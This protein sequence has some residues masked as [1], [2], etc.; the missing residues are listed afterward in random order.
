[1]LHVGYAFVPLGVLLNG[2]AAIDITAPS[3]GIYA[4]TAGAMGL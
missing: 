2:L 1:M 3:A 4:W